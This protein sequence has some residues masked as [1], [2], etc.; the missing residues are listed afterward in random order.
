MDMEFKNDLAG[1]TFVLDDVIKAIAIENLPTLN[2]RAS[3]VDDPE[4]KNCVE[5]LNQRVGMLLDN[6]ADLIGILPECDRF[7]CK[8]GM[9]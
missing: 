8:E 3:S 6:V 4:L 2:L 9:E 7:N 1:F 5:E